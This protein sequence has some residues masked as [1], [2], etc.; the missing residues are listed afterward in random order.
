MNLLMPSALRRHMRRVTSGLILTLAVTVSAECVSAED[1]TPA[2]MA[3]CAAMNHDCGAMAPKQGCCSTAAPRV[4]QGSASPRM[5]LAAPH[6]GVVQLA[7]QVPAS[8]SLTS[9][10]A[11]LSRGFDP[12][13][14]GVPTY[15]LISTFRV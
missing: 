11:Q 8:P 6:A 4:D 3:C 14:P 1:L 2:Q 5:S 15:L 9:R 13:P 7:L 12:K 10:H